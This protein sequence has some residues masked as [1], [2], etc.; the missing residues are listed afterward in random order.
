MSSPKPALL[1]GGVDLAAWA[2]GWA[3][4]IQNRV[5]WNA[6]LGLMTFSFVCL[7]VSGGF[8]FLGRR[9]A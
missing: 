5:S 4:N 8:L 1:M 9:T 3:L 6:Y 2:A 7:L